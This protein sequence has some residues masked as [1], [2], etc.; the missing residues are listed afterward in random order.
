MRCAPPRS[1]PYQ[2]ARN[3]ER[4]AVEIVSDRRYRFA[5]DRE[6]LWSALTRVQDYQSWWPWLRHFDGRAV[7]VRGAAAAPIFA[8]LRH[9]A[10]GGGRA[11]VRHGDDG[12]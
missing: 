7:V 4:A 6:E 12:G 9:R 3:A 11:S 10:A 5:V 1:S 2:A 8:A